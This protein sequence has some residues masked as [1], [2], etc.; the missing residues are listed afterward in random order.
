[1][2]A[3]SGGS[4]QPVRWYVH[5]DAAA[6]ADSVCARIL[7]VA[8]EAIAER[9]VF[10]IVLAGGNTPAAVY[11]CLARHHEEWR[12]WQVY[13]GDERCLPV[14]DPAR[15]SVMARDTWLDHVA[16]P[17]SS[18]HVIP[19]ERGAA[20]AAPAYAALIGSARPFD[21]VLL[22]MGEDGHTASLFPGQQHDGSELVHAVY[23]AP[24]PPAE[25]VSLAERVLDDASVV[26]VLVA[27]IA[28]HAAVARWKAGADMPVAH[29]HGHAGVDVY[30]D[31]AADTGTAAT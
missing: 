31:T 15:N 8:H 3:V 27:G 7:A 12:T 25:R 18:V 5:P 29:L 14:D 10:R 6:L 26:L 13:F 19:A 21:L 4:S 11:R 1:V 22:G 2:T 20:Q 24:K 17:D 28:K 30:L 16:I 23:N 9:G